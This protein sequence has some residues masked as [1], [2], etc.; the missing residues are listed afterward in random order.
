MIA[1][2]TIALV[3]ERTDIVA[4]IGETVRLTRSGRSF[5][6]LCPFHKEKS[7]SFYVHPDRGF[8]HCFGCHESGSAIDFVMKTNGLDFREAVV[9]LAERAGIHVEETTSKDPRAGEVKRDKDEL[10]AVNGL[11]ATYFERELGLSKTHASHSSHALAHYAL[12]ELARRGMPDLA[13]ESEDATRWMNAAQ[14]FRLGYAP[15]GWD[16]LATFLRQQGISPLVAERAGLL[17]PRERGSGHYDRFRHRLMFAVVDPLG[18]VVAFSGRAL[19]PPKQGE[20]PPGSP[21][22]GGES[23]AKYINSPES[24]IYKKG[25]QLFGLFQAKLALRNRGE[26]ILVEGNFDV[27][28]LHARGIDT[29]IAPLG[30]A[31]TSEQAKLLKRFVPK[32][33]VLFDGDAAGRKATRAARGPCRDGGLEARVARLPQGIDPDDLVRT[34]GPRALAEILKNASGMLEYLIQDALDS[35]AFSGASLTE[36]V[37]RVR[38]VAKLLSEEDDPNLQLMG[39]R[40][41]DEL[42]QQL[43]MSGKA[44]GDLVQLE[45]LIQQAV[46]RPEASRR[47]EDAERRRPRPPSR[48]EALGLKV[49][50]ALLDFPGLLDDPAVAEALAS[51]EG[52]AALAIVALR[53]HRAQHQ[54]RLDAEELLALVPRPI[55]PFAAARLASPAFEADSDAKAE[56]LENAQKLR[57]LSWQREKAA[58][59]ESL[60]QSSSTFSPEDAELLRELERRAKSKRGTL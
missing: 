49:L 44:P 38:A 55:H 41:A 32:V 54:G 30:T 2:E 1:P 52:D 35:E 17:V 5:K 53:Q 36:R 11:A 58:T 12:D 25:E 45:R 9:M 39:K 42:S 46:T 10:Y 50:G 18:R 60:H 20:L 15:P 26:A 59:L 48:V 57:N 37:A 28:S 4:V 47:A 14:A 24:P 27:V 29:A 43:V 51:V 23:P 13:E 22:Y 19:A 21:T 56:L 3:K 31:F 7:G 8:Y 6:G 40:Y 33:V 16:G 34:R